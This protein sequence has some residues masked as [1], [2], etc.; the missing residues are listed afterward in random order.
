MDDFQA[1]ELRRR[2]LNLSLM[3]AALTAIV[4]GL[5]ALIIIMR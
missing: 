3:I 1:A 2:R 4:I 5:N